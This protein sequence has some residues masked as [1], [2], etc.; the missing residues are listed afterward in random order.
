MVEAAGPGRFDELIAMARASDI[1]PGQVALLEEAVRLADTRSDLRRGWDARLLLLRATTFGGDPEMLIAPFAWCLAQSDRDPIRFP[2]TALFWPFKWVVSNS[3]TLVRVPMPP[4]LAM[5]ADMEKRFRQHGVGRRAVCSAKLNLALF[6]GDRDGAREAYREWERSPR[7]SYTDCP[8]CEQDNRVEFL[9]FEGRNEAAVEAAE[10]ILSGRVK[11]PAITGRSYTRILLPLVRVGREADAMS[12]HRKGFPLLSR[13]GT[14]ARDAARHITFLVVTDNLP[15]AIKLFEA[16]LPQPREG[17]T[18]GRAEQFVFALAA[19]LLMTRVA[20][21]R[22]GSV[23]LRLPAAFPQ[24]EGSGRYD[25]SAL[26]NHVDADAARLAALFD[27]RNG[28]TYFAEQVEAE[29]ALAEFVRPHPLR[30][31]P[32]DHG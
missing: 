4:L 1:G 11:C 24:F 29:R 6:R 27:A 19:R 26:A 20:T 8:A 7:D 9:M 14:H 10:P 18:T 3:K 15:R 13:P 32:P 17:V 12:Y 30:G 16:H 28:T 25:P 5:I 23:S 21:S 22:A 31:M 2:E